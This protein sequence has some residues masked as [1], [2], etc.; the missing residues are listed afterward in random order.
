[1]KKLVSLLTLALVAVCMLTM[2]C[3]TAFAAD[4][5]A[6]WTVT[7]G[8][9]SITT[10][11]SGVSTVVTQA[12]QSALLT[13]QDKVSFQDGANFR[14]LIAQ[15]ADIAIDANARTSGKNYIKLTAL[16][17]AGQG[18]EFK[19]YSLYSRVNTLKVGKMETD[20][21]Y[22]DP[23][24][25]ASE[26]DLTITDGRHYLESFTTYANVE[27]ASHYIDIHKEQGLWYF[28][29][30]GL[31]ALPVNSIAG[32]ELND[33]TVTM[34]I[35]SE[36]AATVR[37]YPAIDGPKYSFTDNNWMQLGSDVITYLSDDT[38]RYKVA[39]KRAAEFPGSEIRYREQLI[40]TVG[41]DVRE[42]ITIEFS[43]DVSNASAV[44]YAVGLGRPDVLESIDKVQ[45]DLYN[46]LGNGVDHAF[47]MYSDS[48]AAE[49]DGIMFQTTTGLAQPTYR[50]QNGRLEAY[51]TNSPSTGYN[52]RTSMD[53]LTF[54][55]G[56]TGTTLY[57]NG[58]VL[59][60]DLV[61]K[62]SD[63]ESN[64]YMAYPYFHF[65]EDNANVA[66]GNTIVIKGVNAAKRTDEGTLKLVG[67][68]N[69]DLVVG[70]SDCDNG[71]ITLYEPV[72]SDG[73]TVMQQ[74]SSELYS[75]DKQ[76]QQLTVKYGYFDGK[77]YDV[78]NLY[79]RNASGSEEIKVRFSDPTLATQS[80][81]TDQSSYTW[82]K[83][84]TEDLTV[85]VDIKNGI[86]SS[87]SGGGILRSQY[88]YTPGTD[89]S[90]GTIV[91]K[92][93]YLNS[94]KAGTFTYTVRT[95]NVEEE[96]FETTFTIVIQ[97]ENGDDNPPD[98]DNK[99]GGCGSTA[100]GAGTLAGGFAVAAAAIFLFRR[101]SQR[102]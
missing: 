16:N 59:F 63:F 90:V 41:Y 47:N 19:I 68:S 83:G 91:I 81:T 71:E 69:Q 45:Y 10:D 36:T 86:Y 53:T 2:G 29:I 43:Y 96:T 7:G 37:L 60:E 74:V 22:L 48:L 49:N 99:G 15:A 89:S 65:F 95:T 79:A 98:G 80:P 14:Y 57:H 78:Y 87:F 62:L 33:C 55:V 25:E 27:G 5:D 1:M 61:T 66:K 44:W 58:K 84:G 56:E 31:T 18:V 35:Y 50:P 100:A 30:D 3:M 75:Y 32:L 34:E 28:A 40:S 82:V 94:K 72:V 4:A 97:D 46:K 76:S 88:T 39:D 38:V 77:A 20:V 21:T 101:R 64:G 92:A 17:A 54:V 93:D 85:T 8:G 12:S 24:I 9:A 73:Q 23:A 6:K 67:G 11:T 42:P 52:D 13:Y 51:T 26:T 70:L 102:S